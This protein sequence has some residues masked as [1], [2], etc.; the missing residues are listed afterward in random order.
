ME[1]E[2]AFTKR[3]VG[4]KARD[5]SLNSDDDPVTVRTRAH[6]HTLMASLSEDACILS[7]IQPV[8]QFTV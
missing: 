2:L 1:N 3:E 7:H 5:A 8:E 6:A 4:K